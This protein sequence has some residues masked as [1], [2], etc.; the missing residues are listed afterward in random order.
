MRQEFNCA[1]GFLLAFIYLRSLSVAT[2]EVQ[3]T[4][5]SIHCSTSSDKY[6][7][8]CTGTAQI[9]RHYLQIASGVALRVSWERTERFTPSRTTLILVWYVAVPNLAPCGSLFYHTPAV[10]Q[11][12]RYNWLPESSQLA[13]ISVMIRLF[14]PPVKIL[15]IV[16]HQCRLLR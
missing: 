10:N 9:R 12:T 5:T 7:Y 13:K 1:V 6:A 11:A 8:V 3:T 15:K 14:S 4:P 16:G 2:L